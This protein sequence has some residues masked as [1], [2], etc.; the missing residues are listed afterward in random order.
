MSEPGHMEDELTALVD[1]ELPELERARAEEHLA[2]CA[3]CR[4]RRDALERVVQASRAGRAAWDV[5][6]SAALRRRVLEAAF[7]ERSG[8]WASLRSWLAAPRLLAPLAA[9]AA[10]VALFLAVREPAP[11]PTELAELA[12]A[13]RLDLLSD[14]ELVSEAAAA[15]VAPEDL[16]V[17]AHLHELGD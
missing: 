4:A 9:A 5:E 1:G 11:E 17:V 3:P 8:L 13:E 10:G 15:G 16:A 2:S 14:Y 6:P 7:T 12:V